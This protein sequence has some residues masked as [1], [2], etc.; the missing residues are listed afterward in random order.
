M[1]TMINTLTDTSKLD[2]EGVRLQSE[3]EV[4]TELLK[5]CVEENAYN[6]LDQ[7]EYQERYTILVYRYENIKKGLLGI[8]DK[9]LERSAKYES[10]RE[11][12][13]TLEESNTIL[14]EFEEEFWNAI[15]EEV[16]VHA[17]HDITFIFKDGIE[18]DWN[19]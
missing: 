4:V 12:I 5:K 6:A 18:L 1:I 9:L 15:I 7:A 2:K 19:I 3:F 17:E 16:R 14:I 10:I 13:L 11:F 8:N